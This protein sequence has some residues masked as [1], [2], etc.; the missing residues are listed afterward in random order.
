MVG[1]PIGNDAF[2]KNYWESTLIQEIRSAIP[3]I[4]SW[5][6]VQRAL[7]LFRMC[8][9]SKYNYF[10]RHS[11]PRLHYS[12]E[13]S[14]LIHQLVQNGL[15]RILDP[16][17][18]DEFQNIINDKIWSQSILPPKMGGF[19][20][21]DPLL[22]HLPAFIAAASVG[23]S[24]YLHL[25]NV[26]TKVGVKGSADQTTTLD[27]ELRPAIA[28]FQLSLS[29]NGTVELLNTFKDK[30]S[31]KDISVD[32]LTSQPRLQT[33]L[34]SHMY[35]SIKSE[36]KKTLL[37]SDL[38]RLNSCCYEGAVLIT[39]L[40]CREDFR[41]AADHLFRERLLMRLGLPIP[42]IIPGKCLCKHGS[43]DIYGY[44]LLSVC[45][46]G[47]QR[48][49]SHN[50]IRDSFCDMCRAAG[51][52]T[53]IEDLETLKQGNID[54]K[55]RVDAICDNFLPG[56][57]MAFD[58]S[59]ADPRQSGLSLKPI[60]GKAAKKR[61]HSKVNKFRDNLARQ[62]TRFEPFVLESYGRWGFRTRIIFKDLISKIKENSKLHACS[63]DKSVL[64]HFWRCKITLAMHRQ[65]CLGMHTRIK[66]LQ[67]HH[68]FKANLFKLSIFDKVNQLK[69]FQ[70]NSTILD[71]SYHN[72]TSSGESTAIEYTAL[73]HSSDVTSLE[74]LPVD[75]TEEDANLSP[76]L[77][78]TLDSDLRYC[79][80]VLVRQGRTNISLSQLPITKQDNNHNSD[81]YTSLHI[82]T[83]G[84]CN[85]NNNI[86][87]MNRTA[88]WGVAMYM[89]HYIPGGPAVNTFSLVELFG[90]VVTDSKSP[91]FMGASRHTNNTGE[92]TAFGEAI[93]WLMSNWNQL[94][95][96]T[97]TPLKNIVFHSDS[98]YAINAIIGTYRGSTNADLYSHIQKLLREFKLSLQSSNFVRN[99]LPHARILIPT[100]SIR[101]VKAHS[102]I[103][104][105]EKADN[106]AELGQNKVCS[107]GRYSI[108]SQNNL[109]INRPHDTSKNFEVV[110]KS[111]L[112]NN[113]KILEVTHIA[114]E[115]TFD[116]QFPIYSCISP[117]LH[118]QVDSSPLSS[119]SSS[120]SSSPTLHPFGL[121]DY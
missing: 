104:G 61:E 64:T 52:T 13:I 95:E 93:I 5:P 71:G 106:L 10:L 82:Y 29:E 63:L 16:L 4:C 101:K 62:G 31:I 121:L 24:S 73:C 48:I 115:T 3:L 99:D 102:G 85:M 11:D 56:I 49:S 23:T 113:S 76:I 74:R 98:D 109:P 72:L 91:F 22:T 28:D 111:S 12:A 19:G 45:N 70:Y 40:P 21:Q 18:T 46:K 119:S 37:R 116:G 118:Q 68:Q 114:H 34:T 59:I 65:A 36:Y 107:L 117:S 33:F 90:P 58:H 108:S 94:C 44:H 15:A 1:T 30:Y 17:T 105:N 83:D 26:I 2:C 75:S 39:A 89:E 35:A 38:D 120:S 14:V 67:R 87:R 84:S 25:N 60:P 8:I 41:I 54:T 50:A 100:I 79:T 43:N 55:S 77:Q 88:G 57:P 97:S 53:R 20:I 42:G 69:P 78:E 92:L 6:D 86:N 112:N 9:T 27:H 110:S 66:V 32:D 81:E 96:S 7:C 80:P 47:N 51:L 103:K